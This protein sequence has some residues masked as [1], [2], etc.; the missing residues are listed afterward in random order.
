M[1][2]HNAGLSRRRCP[3]PREFGGKRNLRLSVSTFH[4]TKV[5]VKVLFMS[6]EL[7]KVCSMHFGHYFVSNP[8]FGGFS[9]RVYDMFS[10]MQFG[11]IDARPPGSL[12]AVSSKNLI[13]K[14]G[15]P[16]VGTQTE[17]YFNASRECSEER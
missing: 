8:S 10:W 12:S 16:T 6:K 17:E 1:G 5:N 15:R 2:L 4:K 11:E 13:G 3:F 9:G 7:A 14:R